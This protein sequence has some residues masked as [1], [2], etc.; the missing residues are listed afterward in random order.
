MMVVAT[1][2]LSDDTMKWV[3]RYT[4][5]VPPEQAIDIALDQYINMCRKYEMLERVK[6]HTDMPAGLDAPTIEYPEALASS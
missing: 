5:D 1:V 3:K 4:G 2:E 6:T